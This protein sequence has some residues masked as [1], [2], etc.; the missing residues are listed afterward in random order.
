MQAH[1]LSKVAPDR[2]AAAFAELKALLGP[3]ATTAQAVRDHHAKDES[4][5]VPV[6][7]DAVVFP[8]STEEVAEVVRICVRHEVPMVPFGTGTSLEGHVIPVRGGVTID[9]TQMNQVVRVSAEDLDVTVQPG[10]TRKQLNEHLRATGLF[11]PIDPGADA[12]IGGM[13]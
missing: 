13:T 11:F 8:H 1:A 12:S 5:H 9:L 4:W 2:V 10:V 3:R 7:P 6:A